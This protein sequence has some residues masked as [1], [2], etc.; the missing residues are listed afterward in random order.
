MKE[1]RMLHKRKRQV[2]FDT[3]CSHVLGVQE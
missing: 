3:I 1:T 2:W